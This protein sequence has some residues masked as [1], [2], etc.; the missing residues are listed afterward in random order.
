MPRLSWR[1]QVAYGLGEL[2]IAAP[3]SL[4]IFFLLFFLTDV[5]GLSPGLA[6]T[7]LL[8][9]RLWDAVN[10]PLVGWLSD[11]TQSPLGRRY[12]WMVAAALPLGLCCWLQWWVPPLANQTAL[13]LYYCLI[14]LLAYGLYT[15]VQLPFTALAAEL[16]ASYDQR[17]QIMSVKAG[18]NLGGSI[19][20]LLLAQVIF[21]AVADTQRQYWLLGAVT[22]GGVVLAIAIAVLGTYP[23]YRAMQARRLVSSESVAITAQPPWRSLAT[24]HP[25]RYIVGLYL[26]SWLGLQVTAAVL[27]YFVT[28]WLGLT[29]QH[30]TQV[31]VV[32]QMTALLVLPLWSWLAQRLDKQRTYLL[33]AVIAIAGLIG[34]LG[35]QPG[36]VGML[37]G[38]AIL[39]GLGVATFYFVP[40]ALL[41]DVIEQ[42][43]VQT[44]QRREGL[45]FSVLV[46]LQKGALAIALFLTGQVLAG[47]GFVS[48][49]GLSQ[50]ETA[51]WAM[52]LLVGLLP[53][54]LMAGGCLLAWRY[55]LD[56][57]VVEKP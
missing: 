48:E 30:F 10:D 17:T 35:L 41:A 55:P 37:Y 25:F 53:T 24:N 16:A 52:R 54:V 28:V 1:T 45:F 2:G 22:G 18:C 32:V 29:E 15:A 3:V 6:G 33:G 20:G 19:L 42:E 14:S 47:S 4:A 31:A 51:L 56:R 40:F 39:V 46:F 26:C 34:F 12:S 8:L 27:P 13:F 38:Y 50:P 49:A 57:E 43:A 7:T 11:R 23:R 9:G 21:A 5:A 44:G 36:Q